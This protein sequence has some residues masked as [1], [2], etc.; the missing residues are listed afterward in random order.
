MVV[1]SKT[2]PSI[3]DCAQLLRVLVL[4]SQLSLRRKFASASH[5]SRIRRTLPSSLSDRE[6][7]TRNIDSP[8]HECI[9]RK[10]MNAYTNE[11]ASSTCDT[12]VRHPTCLMA[13]IPSGAI[14]L[15]SAQPPWLA[16]GRCFFSFFSTPGG[17]QIRRSPSRP[18]ANSRAV[19]LHLLDC[20]FQLRQGCRMNA[21]G[22]TPSLYRLGPLA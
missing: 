19:R 17:H 7:D 5:I 14:N 20:S 1:R 12:S 22:R 18:T 4:E 2:L 10:R 3:D 21:L 11:C 9:C 15:K 6:R 16:G 13:R 8:S